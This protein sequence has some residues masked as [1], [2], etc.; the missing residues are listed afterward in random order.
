MAVITSTTSLFVIF[1]N[2]PTCFFSINSDRAKISRQLNHIRS[3]IFERTNY[4]AMKLED[5]YKLTAF[6]V[7]KLMQGTNQP[8]HLSHINPKKEEPK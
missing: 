5:G 2:I 1:R 6:H 7:Y 3:I 8:L 4:L